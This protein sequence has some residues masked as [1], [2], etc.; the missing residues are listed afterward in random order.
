MQIFATQLQ[1]KLY[2]CR[3]NKNENEKLPTYSMHDTYIYNLGAMFGNVV[4]DFEPH[5]NYRQHESNVIGTTR[6]KISF[7]GF[8]RQAHYYFNWK[9][10]PRYETAQIMA[11]QWKDLM[12]DEQKNMVSM[13]VNYKKSIR[14]RIRL[15]CC[16]EMYPETKYRI[17]R[18]KTKVL[19]GNI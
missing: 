11:E 15:F 19:L 5:M 9:D 6:R 8:K 18:W 1:K 2:L 4:Y 17:F 12:N 10:Q 3:Q 14:N 7:E 16:E 13:I